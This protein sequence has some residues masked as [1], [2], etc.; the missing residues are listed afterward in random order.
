MCIYDL[1]L[2]NIQKKENRFIC[3]GRNALSEVIYLD[4][5]YSWCTVELYFVTH[6]KKFQR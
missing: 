1:G 2:E 5:C 6:H 4:F 3:C